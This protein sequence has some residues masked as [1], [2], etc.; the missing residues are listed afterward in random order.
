MKT[1]QTGAGTTPP[2]GARARATGLLERY[3]LLSERIP[4]RAK[5]IA[6]W[7][8]IFAV[9]GGVLVAF[10]LNVAWMRHNFWFITRGLW[11]TV[12]IAVCAIFF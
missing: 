10:E 8:A 12:F 4:F 3:E 1:E 7:I 6:V 5:L 9:M 2:P 11:V